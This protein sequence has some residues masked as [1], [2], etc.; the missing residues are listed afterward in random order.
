[1]FPDPAMPGFSLMDEN[2]ITGKRNSLLLPAPVTVDSILL[3]VQV[4]DSFPC[5]LEPQQG[6]SKTGTEVNP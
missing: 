5:R 1:M 6:S 4:L 2:N 3:G